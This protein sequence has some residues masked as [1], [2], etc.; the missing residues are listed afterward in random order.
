MQTGQEIILAVV[1]QRYDGVLHG[2]RCEFLGLRHRPVV[3][4]LDGARGSAHGDVISLRVGTG[5]RVCDFR[6]N[7]TDEN[8]L[9]CKWIGLLFKLGFISSDSYIPWSFFDLLVR[10]SKGR[11]GFEAMNMEDCSKNWKST[12]P[13]AFPSPYLLTMLRSGKSCS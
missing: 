6:A 3:Q 13:V 1:T 4:Q 8:D 12:E 2:G 11:P 5:D 7:A 9:L 10:N